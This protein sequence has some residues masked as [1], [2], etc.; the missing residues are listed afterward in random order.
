M[1][2]ANIQSK[3]AEISL[4]MYSPEEIEKALI[5]IKDA[6]KRGLI[7]SVD[8]ERFLNDF[9]FRDA[10][11]RY[12]AVGIRTGKWYWG[13]PTGWVEAARPT[14]RLESLSDLKLTQAFAVDY[15]AVTTDTENEP[16]SPPPPPPPPDITPAT[17]SNNATAT[18]SLTSKSH[19]CTHCGK[20]LDP[21]D[22]FCINCGTPTE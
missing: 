4:R 19:F 3:K 21:T 11:L 18:K 5:S 12:W 17:Q 10:A 7:E 13:S 1:E 16:S 9:K 22:K 20:S 8:V 6:Y 14:E 15:L 2:H